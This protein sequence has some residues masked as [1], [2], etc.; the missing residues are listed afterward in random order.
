MNR[1]LF[2]G[3][4]T[5]G[6]KV[7]MFHGGGE[8]AKFILRTALERGYAFDVVFNKKL[9]I[10]P[11]IEKLLMKYP[12]VGVYYI[13]KREELYDLI[14]RNKI[15]RF[16]SALPNYPDYNESAEFI[17][18]IHGLRYAE[19]PWD[20]YRYKYFEKWY[21]RFIGKGISYCGFIQRYL[22]NRNI[23]AYKEQLSVKGAKF[24]TVSN[25]SKYSLLAFFPELQSDNITVYYSP[26]SVNQVSEKKPKKDYYLMVSG[27][28]YEKNIYRAVQVFDKL[29][30][31]SRLNNRKVTITGCSHLPFWD[32]IVNKNRFELL[33]YVDTVELESL[34]ENAF[35][36]VYPSLNEGFGYPPLKAMSYGTPVVASSATSIPEICGDAAC[37]FTPTNM[38]DL[39]SRILRIDTDGEYRLFLV[40]K[41]L[42]R[43]KE[44]LDRQAIEIEEE[45][46]MIF[47]L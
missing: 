1:V 24:F 39:A 3:I 33:P 5:Q 19:L 16:Y 20:E 29:F 46:R 25:H 34:Y 4:A 14:R 13:S 36:F 47:G 43:V 7:A 37:Y 45:L 22:R 31:D 8:Y 6:N 35:C 26:F 32:R 38:D 28:R 27:N 15:S 12:Q 30:S 23:R 42:S 21:M 41:G 9:F 44:L 40:E 11:Q 17:G 2:D 10:D 18:V